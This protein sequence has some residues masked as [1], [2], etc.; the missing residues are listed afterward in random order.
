MTIH[1]FTN[2]TPFDVEQSQELQDKVLLLF[3]KK[4]MK[5]P[6][7]PPKFSKGDIVRIL[8]HRGKFNR[9]YNLQR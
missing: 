3:A 8:L 5:T 9:S 2:E 6:R 1:S 7:K 4:Y